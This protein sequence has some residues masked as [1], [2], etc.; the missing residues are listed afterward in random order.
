ME[1]DKKTGEMNFIPGGNRWYVQHLD[2]SFTTKQLFN[3]E[4]FTS[5]SFRKNGTELL[6]ITSDLN[7]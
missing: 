6:M 1:V 3:S 5:R 7:P 4:I 2:K